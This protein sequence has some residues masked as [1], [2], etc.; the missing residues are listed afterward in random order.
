MFYIL[1]RQQNQ[2]DGARVVKYATVSH[3]VGRTGSTKHIVDG[4]E[5]GPAAALA[6]ARYPADQRFY[7]FYLN[8]EGEVVTDT[9][10]D[11]SEAALDQAALE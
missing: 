9:L 5:I 8:V 4:I 10:H 6:V 2:K 7:L 1:F 3:E 11:S